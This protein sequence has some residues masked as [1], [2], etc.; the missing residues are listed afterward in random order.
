MNDETKQVENLKKV[1]DNK[2]E[3]IKKHVETDLSPWMSNNSYPYIIKTNEHVNQFVKQIKYILLALDHLG[4][5]WPD[6]SIMIVYKHS[7]LSLSK[8]I[9]GLPVYIT[10]VNL[11]HGWHIITRNVNS[12]VD[13]LYWFF[14]SRNMNGI[15]SNV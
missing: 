1:I 7:R 6:D 4:G 15:D 8:K 10:T 12:K 11:E 13:E 14:E 2:I 9:C 5:S 3:W